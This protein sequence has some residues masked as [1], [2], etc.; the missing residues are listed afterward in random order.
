MAKFRPT[1]KISKSGHEVLMRSPEVGEG[2]DLLA[3]VKHT[4]ANSDYLLTEADE[5]TYTI[6]HENDMIK[7]YGEH[8]DKLILTPRIDGKI[9]GMMD[10]TVGH[11]RR[12]SHQGEL[13]TSVHPDF[14]GQGIGQ[15]IMDALIEWA[16]Q[17][18]NVQCLRL[19]V[20]S[21]NTPAIS[22]YKKC[23]FVEEGRQLK[24]I[25]FADGSYDDMLLMA[26]YLRY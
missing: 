25:K 1:T 15:M 3:Y 10:F 23:G 7:S 2:A 9:V 21:K 17:N 20:F 8:P 24:A 5:F 18:E 4:M 14:R 11:R 19:R 6:E 16:E 22:L 13:G 26:K 12:A